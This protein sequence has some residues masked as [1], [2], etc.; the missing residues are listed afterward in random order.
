MNF[1]F[2]KTL[3]AGSVFALGSMA[4]TACGGDSSSSSDEN[5]GTSSAQEIILSSASETSPL[6]AASKIEAKTLADG[7]GGWELVLTGSL[8]IDPNYFPEGGDDDVDYWFAFDSLSFIV[9]KVGDDGKNYMVDSL[10]VKSKITFPVERVTMASSFDKISLNQDKIGCGKFVLFTWV[11]MSDDE[12][13]AFPRTALKETPFDLQCK[14]VEESSSSVATVCTVLERLEVDLSNVYD[15][16]VHT[17]NVDGG[18]DA[19]LTMV[20]EGGETYLQAGT[21][22]TIYEENGKLTSGIDPTDPCMEDMEAYESTATT[23]MAIELGMWYIVK[24]PQ[25]TYPFR[26]IAKPTEPTGVLT[27]VYFKK[28][29]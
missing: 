7:K 27:L 10:I 9:G 4:L 17:L 1:K 15:T 24:T 28:K 29:Q 5:E 22:V 13:H 12:E 25:G 14:A 11:Y 19:Q 2:L 18:T 16:D 23:K 20:V 3:L 8:E 26:A 6:N 21:G